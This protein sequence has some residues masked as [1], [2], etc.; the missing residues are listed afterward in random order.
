MVDIFELPGNIINQIDIFKIQ[1]TK[2]IMPNN[3]IAVLSAF[4]I[5]I[6]D[7]YG[8]SNLPL[9]LQKKQA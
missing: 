8:Y 6:A 3:K 7:Y 5:F 1:K 2:H 4:P 9:L